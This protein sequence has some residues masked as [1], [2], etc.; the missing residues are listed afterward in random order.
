QHA[1][2]PRRRYVFWRAVGLTPAVLSTRRA[3][4][5]P[6]AARCGCQDLETHTPYLRTTS[7]S[8]ETAATSRVRAGPRVAPLCSVIWLSFRRQLPSAF[9]GLSVGPIPVS[10]YEPS[11]LSSKP[12]LPR[13]GGKEKP[14]GRNTIS[15]GVSSSCEWI[16]CRASSARSK[17][18]AMAF[19]PCL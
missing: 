16:Q 4:S 14:A 1:K 19:S 6:L 10:T 15:V 12:C 17:L 3:S 5:P 18:S 8:G 2:E 13:D 11:G 7:R 9:C